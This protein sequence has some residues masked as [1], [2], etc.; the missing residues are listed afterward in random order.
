[1]NL[2]VGLTVTRIDELKRTGAIKQDMERVDDILSILEILPNFWKPDSIFKKN[3]SNKV[4]N[5]IISY[6]TCFEILK[7]FMYLS[8]YPFKHFQKY[9]G[10]MHF[11]TNQS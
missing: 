2:L 7:N 8:T 4:K 3:V 11:S 6:H 5:K 1:M 9:F 10:C